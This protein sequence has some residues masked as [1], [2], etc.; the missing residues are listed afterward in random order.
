[1]VATVTVM[2]LLVLIA[3]SML[4]LSTWTTRSS[5]ISSAQTEA[6]TNAKLAL[7]LAI[8][9]LQKEMGPDMRIS[10][11]SAILDSDHTTEVIDGV[12]Q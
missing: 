2:T 3:L 9:E 10:T 1:M 5:V 8:G 11:E 12:A 4:T 6:R 7:M